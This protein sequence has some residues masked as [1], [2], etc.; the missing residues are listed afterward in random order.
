MP[1]PTTSVLDNFNRADTLDLSTTN[2]SWEG[3]TLFSHATCA[4]SSNQVS[5]SG[6]T[7]QNQLWS[8]SFQ[9]AECFLTLNDILGNSGNRVAV[10]VRFTGSGSTPNGYYVLYNHTTGQISLA[11]YVSGASTTIAGP[12][13][14]TISNGSKIGISAIGTT[15]TAWADTGSGWTSVLSVTDTS[16]SAAGK[17]WLY[18]RW[19]GSGNWFADDFGGGTY[20][21]QSSVAPRY[22]H[23]QQQGITG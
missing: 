14:I 11:K 2:P 17:L 16:H 10:G 20:V 18:I 19:G 23:L 8:G 12:T 13:N 21:P 5:H 7:N 9:D 4:I 22:I 6:N 3:T 15:I 1:F